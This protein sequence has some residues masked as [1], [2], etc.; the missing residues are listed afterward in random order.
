MEDNNEETSFPCP[1][2][3][4]VQLFNKKWTIQ[5]I[6]DMFFG[7]TRFNEFKKDKPN[8]S[9]KVLSSCLKDL[10]DNNLIE[11]RI[12]KENNRAETNYYLTEHGRALNKVLYELAMYTLNEDIDNKIYSEEAKKEIKKDFRDKLN[13]E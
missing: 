12:S 8:L 5:I 1:I 11:K 9:N 10:E 7:K 13:I 6:R 4:S 2:E 3:L